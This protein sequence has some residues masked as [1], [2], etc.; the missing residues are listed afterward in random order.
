M[1]ERT[2]A[3]AALRAPAPKAERPSVGREQAKRSE[4][5]ERSEPAKR[6]ARERAGESEG[7]SPS[8]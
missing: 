6:L 7:R 4:P 5:R 2:R 1:N 3:A 8:E